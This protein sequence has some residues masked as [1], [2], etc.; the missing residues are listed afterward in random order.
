MNW[1]VER[2]YG[3]GA[4][5]VRLAARPYSPAGSPVAPWKVLF[6]EFAQL[7]LR[8]AWRGT[9]GVI[10]VA[11]AGL[12]A[13]TIA[14]PS[15]DQ[16]PQSHIE[17]AMF[18]TARPVPEPL[19]EPPPKVTPIPIPP[20]PL[21]TQAVEPEVVARPEPMQPEQIVEPKPIAPPKSQPKPEPAVSKPRL[22]RAMPSLP[23]APA[24]PRVSPATLT[25]RAGLRP[26]SSRTKPVNLLRAPAA[27]KVAPPQF[28]VARVTRTAAQPSRA[29]STPNI[30]RVS[31]VSAPRHERAVDPVPIRRGAVRT[32][33]RGPSISPAKLALPSFVGKPTQEFTTRTVV[34][35]APAVVAR[36]PAPTPSADRAQRD[37]VAGVSLASLASCVSDREEDRLKRRVIAA[38]VGR[39]Q[40]ESSAGRFRF[41][42]T[43]NLNAFLM[44]TERAAS[45]RQADRCGELELALGCLRKRTVTE[46][47]NR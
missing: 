22:P 13:L 42:E 36:A 14:A 3:F 5:G 38:L 43:K 44:W 6:Q 4:A 30:A 8:P 27:P 2:C 28:E 15:R 47:Q 17:I 11:A 34:E 41:V 40:C 1:Y 26:P 21:E 33:K 37:R 31:A 19:L 24:E 10:V 39:S 7:E 23:A 25:A 12:I 16:I 46:A 29:R 18:D 45:R 20:V 35:R 9:A 32:P